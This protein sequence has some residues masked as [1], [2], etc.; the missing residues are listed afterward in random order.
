MRPTEAA[1]GSGTVVPS[2]TFQPGPVLLLGAPGVGKGTQAQR[3]V[4]KYGIPQ[5]STGDLLRQHGKDQTELGRMA[6]TLM[7]AGQFVPD[8]VV[9]GMVADRLAQPDAALGYVLDGFPRTE[10]Q[11]N[12]LDGEL[13]RRGGDRLIAVE[14]LVPRADLL[15]RITGRRTCSMCRHIYNIFFNPPKVEGI[16]DLDGAP[17]VHR[18]DDT[19]DAFERRMVEH[20]EK[21]GAVIAHYR[22]MGSFQ[23]VNG[24]GS[25]DEVEARIN[26]ALMVLRG[27]PGVLEGVRR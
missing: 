14:I 26:T 7:K 6:T 24:M 13:G 15:E 10:A 20:T 9:N 18:S 2:R 22:A 16:C 27:A 17:L 8:D 1:K 23:D 11:A 5:I 12:W 21:T 25:L 19:V 3:L 4:G